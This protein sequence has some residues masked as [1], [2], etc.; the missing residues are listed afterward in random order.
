MVV[1]LIWVC[2]QWRERERERERERGRK[3]ERQ[4]MDRG[5]FFWVIYFIMWIYYS[6]VLHRK[7]KVGMLGV[8]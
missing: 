8:L 4:K 7:I 1:I 5:V 3:E 2:S 6:N